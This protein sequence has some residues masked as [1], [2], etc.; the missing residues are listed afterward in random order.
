MIGVQAVV[1]DGKPG[2]DWPG[3]RYP[4]GINDLALNTTY[5][6]RMYIRECGDSGPRPRRT[7][8]PA[9]GDFRTRIWLGY[10]RAP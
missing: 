5:I 2:I 4:H 3:R 7:P 6:V 10:P 1:P 8:D 9:G